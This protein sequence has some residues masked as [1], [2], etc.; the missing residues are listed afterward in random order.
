MHSTERYLRG[1]A[2]K[3]RARTAPAALRTNW[4]SVPHGLAIS[5]VDSAECSF[6]ETKDR[7]HRVH[8]IL[9][10]GDPTLRSTSRVD[11]GRFVAILRV[12]SSPILRLFSLWVSRWGGGLALLGVPR[13]A[14]IVIIRYYSLLFIII[15]S[16]SSSSSSN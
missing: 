2:L 4:K 9:R 10:G 5:E 11:L 1:L 8:S 6:R 14:P 13:S 16:S 12:H 15:I 3:A 7:V